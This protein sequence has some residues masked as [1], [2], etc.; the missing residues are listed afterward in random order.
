MNERVWLQFESPFVNMSKAIF[1]AIA[2]SILVWGC[3]GPSDQSKSEEKE[4]DG[5]PKITVIWETDE[6]DYPIIDIAAG[7]THPD[8]LFISAVLGDE[9]VQTFDLDGVIIAS[10]TGPAARSLSEGAPLSVS[11]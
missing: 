6:A 5:S 3:S 10:S 11:E 1:P 4:D 7:R 9:R 8:N 2:A